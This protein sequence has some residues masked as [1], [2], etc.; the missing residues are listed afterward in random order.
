MEDWYC[1]EELGNARLGK[2][3]GE[4][5][6]PVGGLAVYFLPAPPKTQHPVM[7][8]PEG[9]SLVVSLTRFTLQRNDPNYTPRKKIDPDCTRKLK[10]E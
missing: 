8:A 10:E 2:T 6:R 3:D 5:I 1:R 9:T 4:S 7:C